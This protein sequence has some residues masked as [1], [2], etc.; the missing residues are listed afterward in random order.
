LQ[1]RDD[2]A[3]I[4]IQLKRY[5]GLGW[6]IVEIKVA[7]NK[8]PPEER[9]QLVGRA[10]GAAGIDWESLADNLYSLLLGTYGEKMAAASRGF[11]VNYVLPQC[12]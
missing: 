9:R 1:C 5:E 4:L 8:T 2:A 6:F 11:L 3:P 10:F 7:E 12:R